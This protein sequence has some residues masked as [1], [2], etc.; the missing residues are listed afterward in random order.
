[1]MVVFKEQ[2]PATQDLLMK[3]GDMAV[4][5]VLHCT[6]LHCTALYCTL[7]HCTA[8]YFTAGTIDHANAG[9]QREGNT[10]PKLY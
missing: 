9:K 1:M 8:L 6:A 7:L 5:T 3:R 10:S 2:P 4:S